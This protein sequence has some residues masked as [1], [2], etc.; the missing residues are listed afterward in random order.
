MTRAR[1]GAALLLG[2]VGCGL[3]P[4]P[5]P[6]AA[7]RGSWW[8]RLATEPAA[9]THLVEPRRDGWGA[10]HRYDHP[11][12]YTFLAAAPAQAGDR[13][14]AA[15]AAFAEAALHDD[16][17]RLVREASRLRSEAW[18][19][20]G[21]GPEG[22][23]AALAAW[24]EACDTLP[25]PPEG[26]P[27][28]LSQRRALHTRARRGDADAIASLQAVLDAPVVRERAEGFVRE[29]VDP[30]LDHTLSEVW[31]RRGLD[32]LGR[33]EAHL[34]DLID[35]LRAEPLAG[36]LFAPWPS[37]DA[38]EACEADRPLDGAAYATLYAPPAEVVEGLGAPT[39]DAV[40]EA[41]HALLVWTDQARADAAQAA[42]G[43]GAELL[44]GLAPLHAY[45][46]G[47]LVAAA[48]QAL[49]HDRP[50][51]ALVL[52]DAARDVS[53]RAVGAANPPA[54]FALLAE[55]RLR[56]GR[57]REALDAL[58]PLTAR[59]PTVHSAKELVGDLA[60]L[61]SM[62]RIGDSKEN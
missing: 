21:G 5:P 35:A 36:S 7:L 19:A 16:L 38:L 22:A 11:T 17:A 39:V 23:G 2:V 27:E 29:H 59:V 14:G 52:L 12:A 57:T 9:F 31:T 46:Q 28:A 56:S 3:D 61:Q 53:A 55:A 37:P 44:A 18:A 32:A 62:D 48:R 47:V 6:S 42:V 33:P 54:L 58:E 34:Q 49:L 8:G 15:R 41:S 25:E 51:S 26:A 10:L 1:V 45:R 60:V 40:R 50:R 13:I 4:A 30:C 43:D 20:R 24:G